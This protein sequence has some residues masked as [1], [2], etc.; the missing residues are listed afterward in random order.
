MEFEIKFDVS[1]CVLARLKGNRSLK[2]VV[3]FFILFYR[4]KKKK[5]KKE[6]EKCLE[7]I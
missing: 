6:E 1:G 3:G 7:W 5:K 4:K 2:F